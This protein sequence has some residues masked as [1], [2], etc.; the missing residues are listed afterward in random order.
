MKKKTILLILFFFLY[1]CGSTKMTGTWKLSNVIESDSIYANRSSLTSKKI[2]SEMT[3][4]IKPDSTFTSNGDLCL[5]DGQ[6]IKENYSQ[7]KFY[8][9]KYMKLDKTFK[10]E[11]MQC[12]GIGGQH[13][14]K[15]ANGKLE[16]YYPTVTGYH[17]QIFKRQTDN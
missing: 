5:G 7:G 4:S 3:I 9:P 17:I 15:I 13:R 1:N 11:V 6:K 8:M 12:P 16:L 10:L 2:D 14:L